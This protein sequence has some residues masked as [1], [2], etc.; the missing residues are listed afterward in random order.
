MVVEAAIG[1]KPGKVVVENAFGVSWGLQTRRTDV[2][3]DGVPILPISDLIKKVEGG[4][5]LIVKIDIEGFESDLFSENIDWLDEPS[6]VIIEPHDWMLP[7]KRSSRGFQR[8]FAER[9]F[10]LILNAEN[11][12]YFKAN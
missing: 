3:S 5:L 11:L 1:A 8:A 12:F 9:D 10:D 4:R 6:L 2:S 7:G